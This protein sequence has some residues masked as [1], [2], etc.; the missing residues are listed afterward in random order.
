MVEPARGV[1]WQ[2]VDMDRVTTLKRLHSGVA[3]VVGVVVEDVVDQS[4]T[5]R[6]EVVEADGVV[7]ATL[8]ARRL[9]RLLHQVSASRTSQP[10][11]RRR[12]NPLLLLRQRLR[13]RRNRQCLQASRTVTGLTRWLRQLERVEETFL[14]VHWH[15]HVKFIFLALYGLQHTGHGTARLRT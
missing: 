1:V 3:E 9:Q 4:T 5:A 2:L 11:P 15:F 10:S 12:P 14:E 6:E 7:E 13:L 8:T